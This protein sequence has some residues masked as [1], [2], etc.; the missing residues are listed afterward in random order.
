MQ[1]WRHILEDPITLQAAMEAEITA[2]LTTSP[3]GATQAERAGP[4]A[5]SPVAL[6][7]SLDA[8]PLDIR[9]GEAVVSSPAV[10]CCLWTS[11]R[12]S[13]HAQGLAA[14]NSKRVPWHAACAALEPW[15]PSAHQPMM[16]GSRW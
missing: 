13:L 12:Q 5:L 3:D 11:C 14:G 6:E 8:Q 15:V 4:P 2:T 1:I 10:R 9:A 7:P 16:L